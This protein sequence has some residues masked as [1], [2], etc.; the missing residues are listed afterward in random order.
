MSCHMVSIVSQG[1]ALLRVS[2]L[3]VA[4]ALLFCSG[5][6]IF[7]ATCLQKLSLRVVGMVWFLD[8]D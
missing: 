8:F 1:L 2:P 4:S 5:H 6:F 3:Y 7:Q